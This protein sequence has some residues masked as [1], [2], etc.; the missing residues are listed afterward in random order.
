[1]TGSRY[2]RFGSL[3]VLLV[4]LSPAV[5]YAQSNIA[6]L[7]TDATGA[8]LPGVTVEAKSPALIEQSR[9]VV[10]DGNGRYRIEDLRPG[11]YTVTFSLP[12]FSQY[13]RDGIVLESNFTASINAQLKVGSLEETVTVSGASPV[14][15]VQSTQARTV[16]SK[17]QM[18]TLPSGRSYQSLA[19]TIPALG[20]ATAGRFDVGGST[21]MWQGTVVAYGSQ[22]GDMALEVD[23][24]NVAS[25]LSTGQISGIY[26]NQS[27]Y[28]EMS[29][30]VVAG[31]AESQTGG[32][33]INMIPKQGG[34]RFSWD[35]VVTYANEDLQSENKGDDPALVTLIV[36]PNLYLVRDYNFSLGGPI[37]RDK[38]W[39][40]FSPR[41]WGA[42]N[43]ILNQFFPDG[44]PARDESL[45][46]SYTTRITANLSSKHKVT[47]LYDPLPKHRDYF[48][49]ELGIYDLKAANQQNM[50]S[51]AIQAKWTGTLTNKLLIEAGYS[52]NYTGYALE[53]QETVQI[54][55][56]ASTSPWGDI[57]KSDLAI[58]S[59]FGTN[60]PTQWFENP[61]MSR[62]IV[63]SVSHVTGSH[64]LK[65]GMQWRF[66]YITADRENNGH[67]VQQYNAGVPLS[68]A[69]YNLPIIS[70][71]ELNSDL[72][73][74][75]QDTWQ[76]GKL[77]LNPGLRFERFNGEVAEQTSPAGRWVGERHFDRIPNL[78]N[79][80]DWVPR[81]G[82]AYD[83][84]GNG[85]T[86][87]KFSVGRYMEQDAS[88]FPERYNPMTLVPSSVSWIDQNTQLEDCRLPGVDKAGCNDIAEGELGCVYRTAGCEI[89]FAQ[90][91]A[92]FG[93]RRNRNPDPNLSRPYQLVYN[94]GIS[95]ELRPGLGISGNYYHRRFYDITFTTDLDKPFSAY[96]PYQINDP[97]GNGQKMTVYN[98][99]PAYVRNLNELDTT[100]TDNR[101]T[102]H[103]FDVGFN[104]RF[105][106]GSMLTGG[107]ASGLSRTRTCNVADPNATWLCND[108]DFG[109]PWRTTFKMSGMYPLP[110]GIRLSGVFQSTAG[111]RIN[112]TYTLTPT[113]FRAQT[114]VPLTVS[115][116]TGLRLNDPGSV[117]AERVNQLDFTFAK[118][119]IARGIRL[120]PEVSLFNALN[121]NPIVSQT[122]AFGP[123]L[124]NPL[125]I[126]EGRLIRLGFQ[127]RF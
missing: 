64:S 43:Y 122:T 34:N 92:T 79:F 78:P 81:I 47:G 127:A 63:G 23:G 60:A 105:R 12:G 116:I 77:T 85:K 113:V 98:L 26:H 17:E 38:V 56:S 108:Y 57:S 70:R 95:R 22:A 120:T 88:A 104:A 31:S 115:S 101:S 27:A 16:L 110:Y 37:K 21:Q 19:A 126:L 41:V 73:L 114:G 119:F 87:L 117:Y 75:I 25:I 18:E 6:G 14:V 49:S 112:Q 93:V 82:A 58:T 3:V 4:L 68:V 89:N 80:I 29:Y 91:P 69:L 84:T 2:A 28:E 11:T 13:V 1:M 62:N 53:P 121:A 40:F 24:M 46:Q 109:V 20:S 35:A 74:Y 118:T 51:H 52:E 9:S 102:F 90:L 30:Q 50:Y 99:D 125:R 36:P 5:S 107:T 59:R 123:A 76:L 8:I 48:L 10:S 45:L 97:R 86:A 7:V 61:L 39:F 65:M 54:G 55:P 33:R 44:S 106:N 32:V 72:G 66:G 96:T 103:S 100:S 67:M 111:D 71:S 15:D 42:Q 124:G 94:A 83:L